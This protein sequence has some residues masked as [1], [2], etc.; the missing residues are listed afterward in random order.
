MEFM[1]QDLLS[2]MRFA[3]FDLGQKTPDENT[4]RLFR[5]K[6]TE[7]GALKRVMKAFDWQLKKK[8]YLPMSGQIVDASLVPAPK[9]RNT[10]DEKE[11]I[12]AGKTAFEIWPDQPDKAR[13]KDVNVRWTLKVGH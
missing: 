3:G 4:I 6:H 7:S 13:Q 10:E 8:G 9:Q 5:N 2:W 11:A 1:L 12:K